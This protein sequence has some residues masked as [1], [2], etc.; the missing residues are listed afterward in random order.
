[1]GFLTNSPTNNV[2]DT[3]DSNYTTVSNGNSSAFNSHYSKFEDVGPEEQIVY[4]TNCIPVEHAADKSLEEVLEDASKSTSP[5][6]KNARAGAHNDV[7]GMKSKNN[8]EVLEVN[9]A[10][11]E[12]G[13]CPPPEDPTKSCTP[14]CFTDTVST[15]GGLAPSQLRVALNEFTQTLLDNPPEA[16]TEV[17][18]ATTLALSGEG[19]A[20]LSS[21]A[22][23]FFE[24]VAYEYL[25]MM[26]ADSF[27]PI[28]VNKVTVIGQRIVNMASHQ[29]RQRGI[30]FASSFS[31]TIEVDTFITGEYLPPPEVNFDHVVQDSF[32]ESIDTFV[33]QL[34]AH[35]GFE[36]VESARSTPRTDHELLFTDERVKMNAPSK[37]TRKTFI[38]TPAGIILSIVGFVMLGSGLVMFVWY[39]QSQRESQKEMDL[40]ELLEAERR[41]EAEKQKLYE[42]TPTMLDEDVGFS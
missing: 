10:Y 30:S 18:T 33:E 35:P 8:M 14:I 39:K 17:K 11:D 7:L 5:E 22:K 25:N 36:T 42:D 23:E 16:A 9:T 15:D 37:P 6:M 29:S 20:E 26:L 34:S 31:S 13:E 41:A 24:Y 12:E 38:E 40:D 19:M 3:F 2:N 28:H 1:V 21:N 4:V 27:P 32:D